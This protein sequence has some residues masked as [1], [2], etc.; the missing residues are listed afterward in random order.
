MNNQTYQSPD[1]SPFHKGEQ[2]IQQRLGVRDKMERFG[3]QV[4]RGFMPEQHQAF[5]NQ[6]PFVFVGHADNNGWPWAS[7]LYNPPGFMQARNRHRLQFNVKPVAGDPLNDAIVKG[8]RL[9]VLGIELPTRRR[10]RLSG[11]INE[12]MGNGFELAIEQTF[13]NCPQYIQTRELEQL[14]ATTQRPPTVDAL[15]TLDGAA[16]KLIENSDTFFVA[17]YL[18]A[19]DDDVTSGVD[20][21]HRGGRPGFVRVD[22]GHTLTIP[23][24]L[25]N[26][27]FNT[28]GNFLENPK[29]GLLF[30]DFENGQLLTLTGT[31][32]VLFDSDEVKFFKGAERLW[33]FKIDHGFRISNTLPFRWRFGE[34]SQNSQLTGTWQEADAIEQ[35]EQRR[36]EWQRYRVVDIEQESSVIKSFFLQPDRQAGS[37]QQLTFQAGQYLTIKAIIN[38]KEQIRT[39]TISSA[40]EDDYFRISVKREPDGLFSRYLHEQVMPGHTLAIK[41]PQGEFTFDTE[42]KRPA[43]LI[44]GGVGITPMVSMARHALIEAVRTRTPRPVILINA[45]RNNSERAFFNE[46]KTLS[47]NSSGFIQS[48]WALEQPE[49]ML[50]G[51][52]DYHHHGRINKAMIQ[53]LLPLDDYDC[54]LCGPAPFMQALYDLLIELGVNDEHIFAE[55]FGPASLRRITAAPLS[56]IRPTATEAIIEFT[57]SKVEQAWSEGDGTLL[58]FAESHGFTPEFS[59]RSGQCGMCKTKLLS[60]AITYPNGHSA[61]IAE[62]ELLLCCAEPAAVDGDATPSVSIK[63]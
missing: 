20:V 11:H 16:I 59:C 24:Y 29:A 1:D 31:T 41:A 25:G 63:L 50:K 34:Y 30:I 21:S 17:S 47:H 26:F 37:E 19:K 60:G 13:G 52:K 57:D 10:N 39:Y 4:I 22:S 28:L 45:A 43:V 8:R 6:L 62:D 36:D 61:T 54:Y 44:A 48:Y 7:I 56:N 42:I 23:D 46:L 3:R 49:S 12:V 38:G 40:P 55:A 18:N 9:G 15:Q 14:E 33:R 5:Y 35:T 2:A 27:H 53:T 58:E 32:E 51:G